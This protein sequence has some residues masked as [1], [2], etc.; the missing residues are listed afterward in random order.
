[1]TDGPLT[2]VV[3]AE[4]DPIF[5]ELLRHASVLSGCEVVGEAVNGLEAVELYREN[6]PDLLLLDIKMP[7]MG[8]LE[9]LKEIRKSFPDAYVVMITAVEESDAIEE[10]MILGARD[11]IRKGSPQDQII[12]RLQRHIRNA[13]D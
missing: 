11:Y 8:G 3:I 2:R 5:M 6:T 10:A 1:M 7:E 13:R 12:T 9:A 4:D